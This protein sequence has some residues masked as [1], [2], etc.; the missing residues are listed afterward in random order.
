MQAS[1]R[2]VSTNIWRRTELSIRYERVGMKQ[3]ARVAVCVCEANDGAES[4]AYLMLVSWR[5][6][7]V[8]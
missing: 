6:C 5:R 1:V 4:Q 3:V 8:L 2:C 7:P